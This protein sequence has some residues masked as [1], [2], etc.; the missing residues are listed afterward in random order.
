MSSPIRTEP[1]QEW[2]IRAGVEP[3]TWERERVEN[4]ERLAAMKANRD[5]R[6]GEEGL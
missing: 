4:A 3:G 5:K 1:A 2:E 6:A